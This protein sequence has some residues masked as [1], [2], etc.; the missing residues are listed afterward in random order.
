MLT[1]TKTDP[2]EF[3][4]MVEHDSALFFQLL[5]L[6]PKL[7]LLLTFGP[8][9]SET[10]GRSE[11][12][13]SFLFATAAKHGFKMLKDQDLWKLWHEPTGR[14]FVVH[15]ADTQGED[16]ITCRIVKNLHQH[17]DL[18]RSHLAQPGTAPAAC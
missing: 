10:R 9:V 8:I 7:H 14:E 15:D 18:L 2:T 12:L 11:G 4:R 6:S 5:L 16:C 3:R 1:N 13:F 17:H